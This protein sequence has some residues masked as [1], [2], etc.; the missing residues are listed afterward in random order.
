MGTERFDYK[1]HKKYFSIK[2]KKFMIFLAL[3]LLVLVVSLGVLHSLK[4][5]LVFSIAIV[6]IGL[7]ANPVLSMI[8]TV[9]NGVF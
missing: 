6:F 3:A 4:Q 8:M 1:M 7:N 9:A 2:S 5:G